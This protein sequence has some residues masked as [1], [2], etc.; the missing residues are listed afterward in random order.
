MQYMIQP[1]FSLTITAN[2]IANQ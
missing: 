1:T 2:I